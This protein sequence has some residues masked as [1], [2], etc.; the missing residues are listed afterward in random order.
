MKNIAILVLFLIIFGCTSSDQNSDDSLIENF[1]SSLKLEGEQILEEEVG[2]VQLSKVD[3]FFIVS[4]EQEPFFHIYDDEMEYIT[5]FGS[6][7]KGP[8]EFVRSPIIEDIFRQNQ[9]IYLLINDEMQ[10]ELISINFT[11]SLRERNLVIGDRY[12]LPS[13]LDGALDFFYLNESKIVGIYDDRFHQKLDK[14]RGGFYYNFGG[15]NFE[16]FPLLNLRIEPFE[17]MAETNIN[18]RIPVL[19][20]DRE[21]MAIGMIHFPRLTIYDIESESSEF[22]L[23]DQNLPDKTFNLQAFQEGNVVEYIRHLYATDRGIY[24][25]YSGQKA[26]KD[27]Q[28]G[29]IK[30]INW[31][32]TPELEFQTA[33]KYRLSM[34]LV[35]ESSETIYGVSYTNDAIYKFDLSSR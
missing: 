32:G 26:N 12:D 6:Q 18:A 11:K 14:A 4:K 2:I 25:L 17:V 15:N 10:K 20:P 7:G 30:V 33:E 27:N 1:P 8:R 29:I 21:K 3:S 13:K 31:N 35:D 22:F 23:L 9:D 24:L 28:Q 19:S 5:A 34:F 16:T